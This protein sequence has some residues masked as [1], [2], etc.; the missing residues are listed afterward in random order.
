M[1]LSK[2]KDATK[3]QHQNLE[4]TVNIM[5]SMF[6]LEDYKQLLCR[7]Y[8]FYAAIE[9]KV[10]ATGLNRDDFNFDERRKTTL[11]EKDLKALGILDNVKKEVPL[12]DQ[13]PELT[14]AA[15]A[16]GS[17]Y[18]MEGA[19]LG[20]QLIS[21]HLKEHLGITAENGGAFF[22]SYGANVGPM[23]KSFGSSITTFADCGKDDAEIIEAAKKTFDSF[24]DC[25]VNILEA[26]N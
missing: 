8:S 10:A 26:K 6:T 12:W 4:T 15:Q 19:T 5:N 2:L 25:F 21:R 11:I 16:F 22:N 7:F 17:I 3:E 9:P 14:T 13:L 24:R 18:V 23:W 20:G 1:I